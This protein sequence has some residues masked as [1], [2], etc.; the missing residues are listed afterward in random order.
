MHFIEKEK[1]MNKNK[2]RNMLFNK[3]KKTK[4]EINCKNN[5]WGNI[6]SDK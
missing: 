6:R 5:E 3:I 2:M 4:D 1:R